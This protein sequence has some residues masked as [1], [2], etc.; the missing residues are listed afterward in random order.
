[1][2]DT[3]HWRGLAQLVG[4]VVQQGATAIERVHLATASRTFDLLKQLP[5]IGAPARDIQ[6][7]HDAMV[8]SAYGAVRSVTQVVSKTVDVA[9]EVMDTPESSDA[10]KPPAREE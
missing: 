7:V 10:S 4:D 3:K 8:S 5:A 1:M 9:L 2:K 6:A